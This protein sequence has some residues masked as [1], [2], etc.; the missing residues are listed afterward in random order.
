VSKT[1]GIRK[2]HS[3]SCAT[4]LDGACNCKPSYEASVYSIRDQKKIRKTFPTLAAAK[5]WRADAVGAL[6]RGTMRAPTSTTIRAAWDAWLAG[7]KD[8]TIRKQG[9]DIYKPSAIRSYEIAMTAVR[10]RDG[11]KHARDRFYACDCDARSL[12]DELGSRKLSDVSRLDLQDLVAT[13]MAEGMDPSTLRN[14]LMPLRA[15]YRRAVLRGEVAVNPT[16]GLELPAVRGRRDRIANPV[17]A[18]QLLGALPESDRAL[19]ATALYAGLRRGE[20]MALRWDDVDLAAGRIRVERS[21]DVKEGA[22]E[23]KSRAGNRIVPIAAVL[24]DHLDEHKLRTERSEG[25]VFGRSQDLPF[26]IGPTQDRADAAWKR[27]SLARLTLHEARHTFA[28]LMIAAGVNAK[29]LSTYMGHSS[30]TITLDRYG[31]LMPGNE[32]EAADLL[33]A[34][35]ERADTQARLAQVAAADVSSSDI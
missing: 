33:Q 23:T 5:G 21:W 19:W 11:C 9:G 2:R 14:K 6:R 13:F 12:L 17:E 27:A 8:G 22:I 4:R 7:A 24:R 30:I 3:R 34:Y 18:A 29:A 15:I 16:S 35:L 31:H 32:D 26:S 20:L 10:H 28:S 25:L 1:T